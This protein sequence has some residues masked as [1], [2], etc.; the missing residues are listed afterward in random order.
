MVIMAT[1]LNPVWK[2]GPRICEKS[3]LPS[4]RDLPDLMRFLNANGSQCHITR[5]WQCTEGCGGWHAD[6][7]Q[8][9]AIAGKFG[10]QRHDP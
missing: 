9:T 2:S 8:P 4:L 6:V 5:I 10:T 1:I 7:E 3:W